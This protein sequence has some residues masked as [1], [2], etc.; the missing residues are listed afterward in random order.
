MNATQRYKFDGSTVGTSRA[1][2]D[3]HL[4][5]DVLVK[6]WWLIEH[7]PELRR[8]IALL[9]ALQNKHISDVYDILET[10]PAGGLAIVEERPTGANLATWGMS[11][12]SEEEVIRVL[13]QTIGAVLALHSVGLAPASVDATHWTF[14][15]EGLLNLSA[16]IPNPTGVGLMPESLTETRR[17]EDV[18]RLARFAQELAARHFSGPTRVVPILS[19]PLL[20][21]L[22]SG[23]PTSASAL[24]S[25][26]QRLHACL[27][28]D[29]HRAMIVY[30][31]RP[32]ELSAKNRSVTLT[33]PMEA[34]AQAVISYD[35]LA[36]M[37]KAT[38]EVY[39]NN[40]AV[41]APA[42]MP[43]SCL[44]TLGAPTRTWSERHFITFDASQPEVVF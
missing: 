26:Y 3:T 40:I 28:R 13:F 36:F 27:V 11:L 9:A 12:R 14:D 33:H 22:W 32:L 37:I 29:Q 39:L 25:Y 16:F 1:A 8:I 34:V 21:E 10:A 43:N 19:D 35:G 38:G 44:L 15:S 4:L 17:H 20:R 2:R 24:D 30:R 18:R 42:Q 7:R 6:P 5:R 23:V 31:Q 41:S